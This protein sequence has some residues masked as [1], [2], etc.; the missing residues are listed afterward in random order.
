MYPEDMPPEL[1]S[2]QAAR[3]AAVDD[4]PADVEPGS[5]RAVLRE[6]VTSEPAQEPE[7]PKEPPRRGHL[8]LVK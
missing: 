8:R 6:V 3:L 1:V 4:P 2:S 5:A 7:G